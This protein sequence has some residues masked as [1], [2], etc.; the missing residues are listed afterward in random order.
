[1][2]GQYRHYKGQEYQVIGI[3]KHSETLEEMVVYQALYG[4]QDIWIR[5]AT[6]FFEDV[7]LPDGTKCPR[8]LKIV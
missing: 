5:P 6:M 2:L 8:F 1:M 7:T 4:E 3:A